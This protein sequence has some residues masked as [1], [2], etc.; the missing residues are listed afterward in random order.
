VSQELN[1]RN[2]EDTLTEVDGKSVFPAELEDVVKMALV[3][4]KIL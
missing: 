4:L 2:C 3:G 1:G